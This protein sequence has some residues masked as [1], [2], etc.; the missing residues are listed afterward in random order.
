MSTIE[1]LKPFKLQKLRIFSYKT[2]DRK[3]SSEEFEA[4]FN[5]ESVRQSFKN[6]YH[7]VPTDSTGQGAVKYSY[8]LP[9]SV[10]MKLIFDDTQVHDYLRVIAINKHFNKH[11]SVAERVHEFTE[12]LVTTVG[13]IHEPGHL[14]ITWGK[15][16]NF[17]CKLNSLDVNYTLFDRSGNPLRAELDVSFV[18]DDFPAAQTAK[19]NLQSP[20]LTHYRMVKEG[21]QLPLMCEEIYGSTQYYMQVAR[22]NKLKDFRNLKPGQEI[23]FPPIAK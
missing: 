23:Y 16:A 13:D 5:P 22:V 19:A 20:D 1:K 2:K 4:M 14:V 3:G 9:S 12:L 10:S 8:S 17:P 15:A 7:K 11:K 18:E 6:H 21:D